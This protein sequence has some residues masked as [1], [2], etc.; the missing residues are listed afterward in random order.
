[1]NGFEVLIKLKNFNINL[2]N[3]KMVEINAI[4]RPTFLFNKNRPIQLVMNLISINGI[5]N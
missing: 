1:M 3:K 2:Q 5:I 4:T